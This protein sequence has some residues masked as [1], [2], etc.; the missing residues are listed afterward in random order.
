LSDVTHLRVVYEKL[1]RQLEK[2]GRLPWIA[3]EMAVLNDP[4]TYRA[5]PSSPGAG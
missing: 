5:I 2:S 4:P 1:R 3:E